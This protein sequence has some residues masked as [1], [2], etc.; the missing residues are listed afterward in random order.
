[1]HQLQKIALETILNAAE[2]AINDMG[3][4]TKEAF[5]ALR[6]L[7]AGAGETLRLVDLARYKE[8]VLWSGEDDVRFLVESGCYQEELRNKS[9]A[10][11]DLL[12]AEVANQVDWSDV[13]V[14]G[15]AA[16]NSII[17]DVLDD[18]LA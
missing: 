16:G 2:P 10:E 11:L 5:E 1:M 9:D 18:M 7:C 3:A 12:I 14:A 17:T 15:T 6:E 8:T 4:E 13:A